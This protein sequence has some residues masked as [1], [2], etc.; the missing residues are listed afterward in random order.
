LG[1]SYDSL[2]KSV[3]RLSS[4]LRIN[5]AKDDAAGLAVRELVRADVAMLRQGSRNGQDAISMLQTAEGAMGVI[6][7]IMVRM[8]ELAE[9]AATESYSSEQ[10][11]IMNQ[12]FAQLAAEID[13]IAGSTK[14]NNISL[15]NSSATYSIHVGDNQ[16]N[17]TVD[18][19]AEHM[20]TSALGLETETTAAV[21][22]YVVFAAGVADSA[23]TWFTTGASAGADT[24]KV[25]FGTNDAS[26]Q[27][28]FDAAGSAY[29]MQ[30]VRDA[31]NASA[32]SELTA[33]I[34]QGT[35]SNYYL[36]VTNATAGL[37]GTLTVTYTNTSGDTAI[38]AFDSASSDWTYTAGTSAVAADVSINS[39]TSAAAALDS[40]TSAINTKDAYRAK[41]GYM[42]NRLEA[43]VS[44]VDIQAENL[45]AAESR[46]SDVD[47]ATEMATMTRN[48]V[49]AQA[50]VA[51]LA[52]ANMMPQMALQLLS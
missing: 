38:Y 42:M 33:A 37:S 19:V 50:G 34:V 47:V 27:I 22:E 2:S 7:D 13:R 29:T 3:E 40:L 8:K 6:N 28:T 11:S 17:G 21:A 43:A 39:V 20:T 51:M 52:Q 25:K 23:G 24:L 35:G 14:F 31:I 16:T 4:G 48:Q 36:Q 18:I 41:L 32:S 15:L 26:A 10:R 9:Q 12:E 44:V 1:N 49:L 5:S 45:M 30:E 46:I